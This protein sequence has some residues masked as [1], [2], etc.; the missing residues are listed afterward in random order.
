MS[1]GIL[2]RHEAGVQVITMHR[3]AKKNAL[4]H[5]LYTSL[6]EAVRAANVDPAVRVVL[7]TGGE[8]AFTAGNDLQDFLTTPPTGEDAPVLQFLRALIT[9]DK[10]VVAAVN[11]L[12]VGIG[13]TMLLHCDLVYV[14]R[15]AKLSAPF[16]NLGLVPEAASSLLLPQRI[17]PARAAAVFFLGESLSAEEAV[18]SGLATAVFD[19][20]SLLTEALQ[21]AQLLATRPPMA[22]TLTRRLMRGDPASIT[23]R[24]A[25]EFEHFRAQLQSA[26]AREAF[27]AFLSR[28]KR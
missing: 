4:T 25:L 15:S 27:A 23:E 28:P 10:P 11:G 26:E 16:V 13:L 1:E 9:L 3:P 18:A 6:A 19:D 17:G 5:A 14:A 2:V 8:G 24:M 7:L 12:A 22:V 21:R 20:A